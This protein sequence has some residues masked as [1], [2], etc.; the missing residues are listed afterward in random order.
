MQRP[1]I[2]LMLVVGLAA[3]MYSLALWHQDNDAPVHI[4]TWGAYKFIRH[5]FYSSFLWIQ[6]A[7]CLALPNGLLFFGLVLCL[8]VLTRTAIRE[9]NRLSASAFGA[10][11][12]AYRLT[13]GR[14]FLKFGTKK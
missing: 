11:Y 5:P 7:S 8:F 14:F 4:V 1:H 10:E 9:E 6:L 12:K 2:T 13:T 3:L